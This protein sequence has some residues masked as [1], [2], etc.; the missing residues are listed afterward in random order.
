MICNLRIISVLIFSF[1]LLSC[2]PAKKKSDVADLPQI[3]ERGTLVA[4]ASYNSVDYFIYKGATM[5]FHYELLKEFAKYLNLKLEVRV[6]NDLEN[7]FDV[8]ENGEA[9]VIAQGLTV[10]KGRM[11]DIKFSDP[12]FET[13][14]VLV[15]RKIAAK[16]TKSEPDN[17]EFITSQTQLA[18]KLVY[19]QNNSAF[20]SR[21]LHLQDEIGDTIFITEVPMT[22]EELAKLVSQ[23]DIDYTVCDEN[24]A[25]VL[26]GYLPNIDIGTPISLTQKIAWGVN[27]QNYELQNALNAWL[28]TFKQSLKYQ[29]IYNKYYRYHQSAQRIKSDYFTISSGKISPY[30]H[31]LKQYGKKIGWDWRLLASIMYQESNFNPNLQ[32]WAGAAGLMQLMP[33]TAERFGCTDLAS[34]SQNIYAATRF[35]QWLDK[36][37]IDSV[38]D[39]TERTKFVLA[40]YNVGLGHIY[41]ARRLAVKFGKN[42]KLWDNHVDYFLLNKSKPGFYM[43]PLVQYGYCRGEEPYFY[44]NEVLDRYEHYKNIVKF[45]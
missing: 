23:G 5:G 38:P 6:T 2:R 45:E 36:R 4:I 40:S 24:L 12:L 11:F 22:V 15:Q 25:L 35:L 18:G 19:I 33:E 1:F 9:D 16:K 13:N 10:T 7:A 37:L 27:K 31:Y 20:G 8:I 21:L 30:D 39:S 17:F 26:S 28:L 32:S 29:M 41:D 43:D 42:P 44:V 3:K 34:P 14:Q